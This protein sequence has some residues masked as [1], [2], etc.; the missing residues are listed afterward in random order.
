MELWIGYF[1][2]LYNLTLLSFEKIGLLVHTQHEDFS[3]SH[4]LCGIN[5]EESRSC[6][7][8]VFTMLEALDF[9]DLL[10]ISLQKVQKC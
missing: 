2:R 10:N 1:R 9:V 6:K 5:F 3:V 7:T 8:T 4:L